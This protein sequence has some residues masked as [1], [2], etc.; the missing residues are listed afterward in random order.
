MKDLYQND[1]I[2]ITRSEQKIKSNI[3]DIE[4]NKSTIT[5]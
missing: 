4:L 3:D 5:R 1:Q 2:N